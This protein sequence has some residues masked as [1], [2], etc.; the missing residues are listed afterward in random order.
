[1]ATEEKFAGY[2]TLSVLPARFPHGFTQ[3]LTRRLKSVQIRPYESKE[4]RR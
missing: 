2:F 3:L 4:V 1:M